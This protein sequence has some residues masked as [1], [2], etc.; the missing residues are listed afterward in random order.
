MNRII[1]VFPPHQQGQVRAQLSMT[2]ESVVTQ[3]L[4]PR[5]AAGGVILGAEVMVC[6]PAIRALIRESKVHEMYGVLQ[7]SQKYGMLTMNMSLFDL[8]KSGQ[9]STERALNTSNLPEE[10]ERMLGM[11]KMGSQDKA[12]VLADRL[13]R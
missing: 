11:T 13:S 6:T 12:R 8:V 3:K 1:D 5:K 9:V 4:M 10:L 2:L 7:V